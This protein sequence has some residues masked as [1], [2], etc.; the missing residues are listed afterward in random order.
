MDSNHLGHE[1]AAI[2]VGSMVLLPTSNPF[3]SR[4]PL[5]VERGRAGKSGHDYA[6]MELA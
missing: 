4:N 3:S 1:V 6:G 2:D 5:R